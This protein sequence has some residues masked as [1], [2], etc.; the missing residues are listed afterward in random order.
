MHFDYNKSVESATVFVTVKIYQVTQKEKDLQAYQE[1]RA[2]PSFFAIHRVK[3]IHIKSCIIK[4]KIIY[5]ILKH[6]KI[7]KII[8]LF[9]IIYV[10]Q[11]SETAHIL[12]IISSFFVCAGSV[13]IF[14]ICVL[15]LCFVHYCFVRFFR[16]LYNYINRCTNKI[17]AQWQGLHGAH[18]LQHEQVNEILL[19][20]CIWHCFL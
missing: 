8:K 5:I 1:P 18:D 10:R 15:T 17:F 11:N 6:N 20:F 13:V 4:Y 7:I 14:C 9:N 16:I 19:T 12:N 3:G 2:A